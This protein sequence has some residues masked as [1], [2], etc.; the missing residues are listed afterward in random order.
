M[1]PNTLML[2]GNFASVLEEQGKLAEA[3]PLCRETVDRMRRLFGNSHLHQQS[4]RFVS[5]ARQGG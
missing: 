5:R 4:C 3:E 1:H 2:I